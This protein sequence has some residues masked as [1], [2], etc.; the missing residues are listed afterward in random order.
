[1]LARFGRHTTT[2]LV[3]ILLNL[4]TVVDRYRCL[5]VRMNKSVWWINTFTNM[6]AYAT[7]AIARFS[8][9]QA[10]LLLLAG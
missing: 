8:N 7:G 4:E 10:A 6:V 3:S 5:K 2:R 9:A 1:M